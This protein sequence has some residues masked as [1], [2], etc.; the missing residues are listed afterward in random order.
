MLLNLDILS[1]AESRAQNL[2]KQ[3]IDLTEK[4]SEIK[5][6]MEQIEYDLRPEM[7]D[8]M[9]AFAGTLRPEELRSMRRKSLESEKNNLQNLLVQIQSNTK[10]I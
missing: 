5:T 1:K 3:L 2:R 4:E 9:V 7:I 10:S 8:R 6:K